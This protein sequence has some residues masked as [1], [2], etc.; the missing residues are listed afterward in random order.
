M[1]IVGFS[2]P[3]LLHERN[4]ADLFIVITLDLEVRTKN[5]LDWEGNG[6]W[7]RSCNRLTWFGER[8]KNVLLSTYT[9]LCVLYVLSTP[10]NQYQPLVT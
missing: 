3:A 1:I 8:A 7:L 4:G 5:S 10:L 2:L 6:A 9:S